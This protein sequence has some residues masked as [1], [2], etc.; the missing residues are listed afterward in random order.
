MDT[1]VLEAVEARVVAALVEKSITTPQYYPMTVNA[2]R[3]ATNQKTARRPVMNLDEGE[4]GAALRH[5]AERSLVA[6]DDAGGRTPKWR[7]RLGH[8]LLVKPP[9][10]A[11]LTALMLRGPQT[12]SELRASAAGLGGPATAADIATILAEVADRA[13]PLVAALP[14]QPGQSAQRFTHLLCG[15]VAASTSVEAALEAASS[16]VP[17]ASTQARIEALEA[18]VVELERRLAQLSAALGEV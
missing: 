11:V 18:R 6:R 9:V 4:V 7:H 5:L 8:E 16:S 3:Q 13:Q 2:V 14:R 15:E 17:R 1:I 10:L 12:V